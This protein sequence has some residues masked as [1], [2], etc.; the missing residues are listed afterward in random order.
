MEAERLRRV[1]AGLLIAFTAAGCGAGASPLAS[2]AAPPQHAP[3][4][5]LAGASG[6]PANRGLSSAV[7]QCLRLRD[8]AAGVAAYAVD[9]KRLPFD[10]FAGH[11][12]G[13]QPRC[14]SDELRVS[15]LAELTIDGR[16]TYV[17]R[18]GCQT[19]CVARQ[20]TVHVPA[21]VFASPVRL[22]AAAARHGDGAPLAGCGVRVRDAPQVAGRALERMFYKR[23]TPGQAARGVST[24]V[25]AR[26]SNYGDPGA[27]YR[28]AGRRATN[29]DYLLWNL[30]RTPRAVLHGGGIV[31][32]VLAQ[33]DPLALCPGTD[34]TLPAWAADGRP[35]GDLEFAYAAVRDASGARLYGWVL[36]AY[37]YAGRRQTLTT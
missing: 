28:A 7:S 4:A 32:A 13:T 14:R 20:A 21:G 31:E 19:P 36:V 37:S 22:L 33:G 24:D 1:S 17:R 25:G 6:G 34:L 30:P 8:P 9:G 26:W 23:P 27:L 12:P 5:R 18:G 35:D 15:R 29:Y 10:V 3:P 11:E 16:L 2:G